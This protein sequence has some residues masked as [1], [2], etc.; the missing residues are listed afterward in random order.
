[1]DIEACEVGGKKRQRK[2]VE[3]EVMRTEPLIV[4][5]IR[6]STTT[7]TVEESVSEVASKT[8]FGAGPIA[9]IIAGLVLM[10]VLAMVL[11]YRRR[12]ASKEGTLLG[13]ITDKVMNPAYEQSATAPFD[14]KENPVVASKIPASAAAPSKAMTAFLINC[15]V[16]FNQLDADGN[17]KLE[18]AE[19]DTLAAWVWS[20]F[21]PAG[22]PVTEAEKRSLAKSILGATDANG[23]GAMDFEEFTMYF[24]QTTAAIDDLRAG[25][26]ISITDA[27]AYVPSDE[28]DDGEEAEEING[29]GED[30]QEEESHPPPPPAP[31]VPSPAIVEVEATSAIYFF[32]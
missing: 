1:M 11:V 17:G 18:G 30:V 19:L 26:G 15:K 4:C 24:R 10:F 25:A 14:M 6:T 31:P 29:F 8:S 27:A 9:G 12:M 5:S 20:E 7:T 16:K 23:D 21:H 32:F 2:A 3:P 22:A 13:T 28:E